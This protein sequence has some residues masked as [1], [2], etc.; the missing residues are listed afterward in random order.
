MDAF[1]AI[2]SCINLGATEGNTSASSNSKQ[3][4]WKKT[5]KK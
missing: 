3:F 4:K 1:G 2:F 5:G